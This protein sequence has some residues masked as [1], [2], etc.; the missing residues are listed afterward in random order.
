MRFPKANKDF[1]MKNQVHLHVPEGA[2]PK[3]GNSSIFSSLIFLFSF[4]F[5]FGLDLCLN[6]CLTL[7]LRPLCW[8]DYGDLLA[9]FGS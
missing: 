1:F 9:F 6:L 4:L 3:D 5:S 2:T 8:C 7:F